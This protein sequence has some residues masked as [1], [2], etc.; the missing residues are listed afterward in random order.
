MV[1]EAKRPTAI[2][3]RSCVSGKT[4]LLR[5]VELAIGFPC[6]SWYWRE[7]SEELALHQCGTEPWFLSK[8]NGERT[9]ILLQA[10]FV[11]IV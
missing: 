10:F 8:S 9:D 11:E 3:D 5:F 7:I 2:A 1:R 6:R 4:F